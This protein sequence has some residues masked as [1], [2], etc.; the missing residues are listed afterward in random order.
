MCI[1]DKNRR[2]FLKDYSFK[3]PHIILGVRLTC[4]PP[5]HR[6]VGGAKTGGKI[7]CVTRIRH[8]PAPDVEKPKLYHK[9]SVDVD[10]REIQPR[11]GGV[12]PLRYFPNTRV[13]IGTWSDCG[14]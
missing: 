8:R 6:H 13:L 3:N 11:I 7:R 12:V 2:S 1:R 5:L 10:D 4:R 14:A 9:T